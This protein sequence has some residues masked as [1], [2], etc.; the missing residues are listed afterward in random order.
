MSNA[1]IIRRPDARPIGKTSREKSSSGKLKW[2]I[3]V[4]FILLLTVGAWAYFPDADPALARIEHIRSQFDGATD[5]QRRELFSQMRQE[6]ENLRPES[7]EQLRD[8]WRG[9]REAREQ[10]SLNE[11][12]AMA[13]AEQ[14]KRLDESIDREERWRKEREQRRAQGGG[15]R[16]GSQGRRGRRG[17]SRDSLERRKSYLD[18]TAPQTRAQRSEY[19]RMRDA[20]RRERGLPTS[21]RWH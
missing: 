13:P 7:R 15:D 17:G 21:R 19:R 4:I 16:A 20:R 18:R 9:K 6:Y 3:A 1:R 2:G 8:E 12:F 14:A 10:K 5:E 11:F